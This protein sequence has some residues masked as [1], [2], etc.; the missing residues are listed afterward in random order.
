MV[1]GVAGARSR[2]AN[3]MA[4]AARVEDLIKVLLFM[5]KL[6]H[7][8]FPTNEKESIVQVHFLDFI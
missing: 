3:P 5:M 1:I 2:P 8:I 6:M 7:S 4:E